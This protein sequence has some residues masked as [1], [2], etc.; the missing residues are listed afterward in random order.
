ML[1]YKN[2][3]WF[4]VILAILM[5]WFMVVLTTWVFL[6]VLDENK[7]T[8]DMEYYFKSLE[9]A[10]GWLELAM[11]KSKQYNYSY[12]EKLDVLNPIS[13]VLF[14]N[15]NQFNKKK[16]VLITYDISSKSSEIT[17]KKIDVWNFE[18]IPLFYYNNFWIYSKVKNISITWLN[19]D[20]VWNIVWKNSWIS[21]VWD[22]TNT[23]EWN[24][25]TISWSNV[26]FEKKSIWDFLALEDYN[27]LII[28]NMSSWEVSYNLKSLNPWE[29]FTKDK[30]LIVSSWEVW[31]F[32]QNL[33]ITINASEYLNLLKYSIFSN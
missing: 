16:D 24:Y 5:T 2:N 29:Y 33:R 25:K 23:S 11:L 6:L 20:V 12:D 28:H 30:L 19:P 8:K 27:Y 26:S 21:W 13:K 3:S 1:K 32:K 9:W 22:F 14:D 4:S 31:W 15:Q 17:D 18:I 10:E 7:D